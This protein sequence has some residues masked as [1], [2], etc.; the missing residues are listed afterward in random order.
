MDTWEIPFRAGY[1]CDAV[2]RM[3]A[4]TIFSNQHFF[5]SF[6]GEVPCELVKSFRKIHLRG[7]NGEKE[8]KMANFSHFEPFFTCLPTFLK[9]GYMDFYEFDGGI[10]AS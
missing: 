10:R 9:N 4:L 2:G 8:A 7:Q 1:N 3:Y 6:S 5:D